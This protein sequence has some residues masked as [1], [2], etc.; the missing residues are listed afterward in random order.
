VFCEQQGKHQHAFCIFIHSWFEIFKTFFTSSARNTKVI[1]M[2]SRQNFAIFLP[3]FHL[4]CHKCFFY[5]TPKVAPQIVPFSFGEEEFNLDDSVSTI[6]SITK[7]DLPLN[8]W[9]T[10]KP[11]NENEFPY[12]LTT[13]DGIVI[14]RNSAKMSVLGIESVKSRH[15]GTYEC[16]AS[17]KANSTVSSAFLSINGLKSFDLILN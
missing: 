1:Q 16:F 12:N 2:E 7:G 9:W 4:F 10:F 8:I 5:F 13:G 3:L 15:R 11:D 17:N 6:C 14:T